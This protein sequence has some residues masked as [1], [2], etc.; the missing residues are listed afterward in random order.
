MKI[1][2]KTFILIISVILLLTFQNSC[3]KAKPS[4]PENFVLVHGG[5]FKMGDS[6]DSGKKDNGDN[7][8]TPENL[9]VVKS[10]WIS[11]YELTQKEWLE[12]TNDNPSINKGSKLPVEKISWY[13][14]VEYCNKKSKFE[15]LT[16]CYKISKFKKDPKNTNEFDDVK[17]V[18]RLNKKGNGYRLPTEEEWEYAARYIDGKIWTPGSNFSGAAKSYMHA[19]ENNKVAWYS[20][21][22]EGSTHEIGSK[23]P[24]KLD[25]YDMSGNVWEWCWSTF[26]RYPR[27][28]D[29]VDIYN[30]NFHVLRGGAWDYDDKYCRVTNR[31]GHGSN[32]RSGHYG[33][34]L[35]RDALN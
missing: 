2:F 18:V 5:S 20:A 4:I 19:D 32:L 11:K 12:I 31:T 34:R 7:D 21:N 13:D 16:P 1:N 27:N 24:N 22:S 26:D 17:W 29:K 25:I 33:V 28:T 10:F 30:K 6:S 15:G 23:D 14:A 35:V 8:E 9:V 3:T